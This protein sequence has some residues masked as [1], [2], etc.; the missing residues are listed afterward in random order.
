VVVSGVED[1]HEA[2]IIQTAD[3]GEG[4]V[5][6]GAGVFADV[7]VKGRGEGEIAGGFEGRAGEFDI[8]YVD[9]TL[10]TVEADA[11][12]FEI[13]IASFEEEF[14]IERDLNQVTCAN[15]LSGVP[16]ACG[17]VEIAEAFDFVPA[18]F[19]AVADEDGLIPVEVDVVIIT[20]IESAEDEAAGEDSFI[21]RF[22]EEFGA[23]RDVCKFAG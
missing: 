1:G 5:A 6:S 19:V 17:L 3:V 7:G 20:A 13:G 22:D 21:L 15:D 12:L 18:G 9:E 16:C 14:A 2:T 8:S 23:D 10:R 4:F 11:A